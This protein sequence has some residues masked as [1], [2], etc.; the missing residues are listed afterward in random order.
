MDCQFGLLHPRSGRWWNITLTILSRHHC[1]LRRQLS[2][3]RSVQQWVHSAQ[4]HINHRR[5]WGHMRHCPQNDTTMSIFEHNQLTFISVQPPSSRAT[6]ATPTL[7]PLARLTTKLGRQWM[8]FEIPFVCW[9]AGRP[10]AMCG[11]TEIAKAI[12]GR[13]AL[14]V[15]TLRAVCPCPSI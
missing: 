14:F 3:E 4:L 6:P 13:L 8:H 5:F 15:I 12:N 11:W 2:P 9:R 10:V 1:A 7:S